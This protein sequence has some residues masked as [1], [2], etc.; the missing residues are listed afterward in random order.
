MSILVATELVVA[1]R[2]FRLRGREP[3]GAGVR[4]LFE[5][6]AQILPADLADRAFGRDVEAARELLA[7]R[8]ER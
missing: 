7:S 8:S 3:S 1:M 6:A 4:K 2:A 5:A